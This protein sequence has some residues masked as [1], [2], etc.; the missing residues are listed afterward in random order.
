MKIYYDRGYWNGVSITKRFYNSIENYSFI[1]YISNNR[2]NEF[3]IKY[4]HI[5]EN[6][7]EHFKTRF[8]HEIINANQIRA[9]YKNGFNFHLPEHKIEDNFKIRAF[10]SA[11]EINQGP[12]IVNGNIVNFTDREKQCLELMSQGHSIKG[13]GRRLSLSPRTIESHIYN[14]KQKT[15]YHYKYDLIQIYQEMLK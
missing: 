6:F 14:V 3:F 11:I 7:A 1:G 8:A 2:I 10:L 15:G 12:L 9:K 4:C 13:I 5:L